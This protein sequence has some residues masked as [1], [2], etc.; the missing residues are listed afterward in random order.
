MSYHYT[1]QNRVTTSTQTTTQRVTSAQLSTQP[2]QNILTYI[3]GVPL[4]RTIQQ[5]LAYGQQVGLRG[6]HTHNF[7]GVVG[8]MAGFDHTEAS[9][10][11]ATNVETQ[12][13]IKNFVIKDTD[14]TVNAETRNFTINGDIG[15]KFIMQV[16]EKPAS[17]SAMEKYYNFK[18]K[19]FETTTAGVNVNHFLKRELVNN[20]YT[21]RILFPASTSN[22]YKILLMADPDSPTILS[23]SL[24]SSNV[25]SKDINDVANTTITFVFK[26][27][28]TST[29]ASNPPSPNLTISAPPGKQ[30]SDNALDIAKTLTNTNSDANGFG[31]RITSAFDIETGIFCEKTHTING[32]VSSSK[33]IVLDSVDGIDA[34]DTITS[35]SGGGDSLSGTPTVSTVDT[36]TN[37]ITLTGNN[38]SFSDGSTL[39]FKITGRSRIQSAFGIDFNIINLAILTKD[40]KKATDSSIDNNVLIGNPLTVSKTVRG[41]ISSGAGL[42]GGL[43]LNGTYGLSGG[44]VVS[45]LGNGI[46]DDCLL[47][48]IT[49]SASAG[50]I[51]TSTTH[52]DLQSGQKLT[53]V[54]SA[55]TISLTNCTFTPKVFPNSNLTINLDL[56]TFITPGTAT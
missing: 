3:S 50:S 7:Q 10:I 24:S 17:S 20:N 6:Y 51:S 8:Y 36:E 1:N 49:A 43:N 18:T 28:N 2:A 30:Q 56:D 32:A 31:L 38:Q 46:I 47:S 39:T 15:S 33:T 26:T 41:N 22:G 19:T 14:L 5:A 48:E 23:Q 16:I 40:I 4:F 52:D 12:K 55:Q 13:T 29:Y 34:R 42:S 9:R 45:I 11:T 21:D 44:N 53:F 37:T 25:F 35:V 27:A 54:G